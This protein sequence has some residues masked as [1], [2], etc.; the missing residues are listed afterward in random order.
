MSSMHCKVN[1]L[2][3]PEKTTELMTSQCPV[4]ASECVVVIL[5]SIYYKGDQNVGIFEDLTVDCL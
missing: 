2:V 4:I 5:N 3:V 1:K